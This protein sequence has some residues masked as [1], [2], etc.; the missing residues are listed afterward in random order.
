[1]DDFIVHDMREES[2]VRVDNEV[3]LWERDLFMDEAVEPFLYGPFNKVVYVSMDSVDRCMNW[4]DK[5][6]EKGIRVNVK[7]FKQH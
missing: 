6:W 5:Q 7:F 1:M 3:P 4:M 2:H